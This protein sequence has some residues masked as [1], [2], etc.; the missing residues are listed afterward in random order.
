VVFHC[1]D[2][3][4]RRGVPIKYQEV[5]GNVVRA[6]DYFI[7]LSG[8]DKVKI[9]L[10]N[11]D[12]RLYSLRIGVRL[13]SLAKVIDRLGY[14]GAGIALDV[15]HLYLAAELYGFNLLD[16]VRR[17]LSYVKHLHLNDNMGK[18]DGLG[19]R[20]WSRGLGDL[21][22]P[23]GEGNAPIEEVL[24]LLVNSHYDGLYLLDLHPNSV[25]FDRE[26]LAKLTEELKHFKVFRRA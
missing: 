12:P 4:P 14:E 8:D 1:G 18:C 17:N 25:N 13:T 3:I 20:V 5:M 9:C 23:P 6:I 16:E 22:L 21:H 24:K 10:E 11:D 26:G 2:V 15:G 19:T 7:E